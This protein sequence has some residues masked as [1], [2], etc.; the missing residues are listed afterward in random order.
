MPEFR[1]DYLLDGD[2]LGHTP[3][4][5]D[6]NLIFDAII[7]GIAAGRIRTVRQISSGEIKKFPDVEALLKPYKQQFEIAAEKQFCD[8]VSTLL[9]LIPT[10][11]PK[12][13]QQFGSN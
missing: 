1:F 6:S 12:L 4:R 13:Y 9:D 11:A 10:F 7:E 8:E 5:P 3:Y 2:V